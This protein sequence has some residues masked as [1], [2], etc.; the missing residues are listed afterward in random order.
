[1]KLFYSHETTV[2]KAYIIT[3]FNNEL[4]MRHSEECQAS[5]RSVGQ[6]HEVWQAFDG[7]TNP[8]GLPVIGGDGDVAGHVSDLWVDRSEAL[9]RYLE[10]TLTDGQRV[11]TPMPFARIRATEVVVNSILSSQFGQVPPL[12]HAD[13]ITLL[14]EEKVAAYYGAGTLY[15]TP[16]RQE[17]L[18]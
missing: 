18:F 6:D 4:S 16:K 15:A 3:M 14:E 2:E 12:R 8:I 17:P 9:F 1:M 7:D 10:V 5:C 11:L 13:Q